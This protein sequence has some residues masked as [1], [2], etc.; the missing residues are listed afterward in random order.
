MDAGLDTGPMLLAESVEIG[1]YLKSRTTP[2][3]RI[4]ILGSETQIFFYSQR[5]SASRFVNTYF[6]TADHPR[7]REM[8]R[9]MIRDIERARPKY[10][11]FAELPTSWLIRPNS[12]R[13]ILE[14]IGT[15]PQ[16]R[17]ALE[18][19]VELSREG[20]VLRWGAEARAQPILPSSWYVWIWR[21]LD[22]SDASGR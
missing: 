22:P 1:E 18:G 15:Y 21:R 11:L 7:N 16:G 19:I 4:A 17:Y 5:R 8:Q 3:D 2:Q 10:L 13:D 9:E 20:S 6:L 12:P 14:W